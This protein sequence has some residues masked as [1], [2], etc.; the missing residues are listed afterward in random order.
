MSQ[1]ER[2]GRW[3]NERINPDYYQ[4]LRMTVHHASDLNIRR[5]IVRVGNA[6]HDIDSKLQSIAYHVHNIRSKV[7]VGREC[8][9]AMIEDLV[10][11]VSSNME[12][13]RRA[14]RSTPHIVEFYDQ[15]L[16]AN[17]ESFLVQTKALLDSLAQFYSVTFHREIR[18]FSKKGKGLMNDIRQLKKK[19]SVCA[20]RLEKL[21][22][23]AKNKWIDQIIGY[24]DVVVHYGQLREL[25]CPSLILT[26][27]VDY[28]VEDVQDSK[29]PNGES[30]NEFVESNLVSIFEFSRCVIE[31]LFNHLRLKPNVRRE[32]D[33]YPQISRNNQCPC[34]AD[35]KY[36]NCHGKIA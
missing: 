32:V 30:L 15:E 5:K 14:V 27:G 8:L 6:Y 29:L 2:V 3:F 36:K 7:E 13:Y 1:E 25:R 10:K 4:E 26:E 9:P 18:T 11:D 34:G 23:S 31:I 35:A 19:D 22:E 17:F 24:R 33:G 21:I 20:S 28:R 16:I 12:V